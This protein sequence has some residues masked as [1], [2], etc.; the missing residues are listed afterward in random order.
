MLELVTNKGL[1]GYSAMSALWS[2]GLDFI[3]QVTQEVDSDTWCTSRVGL[4]F[5]LRMQPRATIWAAVLPE[6][7]VWAMAFGFSW[8]TLTLKRLWGSISQLQVQNSL[9]W[10]GP[11]LTSLLSDSVPPLRL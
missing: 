6:A 8:M 11:V 1:L 3:P 4:V 10:V 2:A 9:G 7:A 5:I